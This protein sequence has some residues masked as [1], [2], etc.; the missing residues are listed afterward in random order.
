MANSIKTYVVGTFAV[1]LSFAVMFLFYTGTAKDRLKALKSN[2]NIY[3]VVSAGIS[4]PPGVFSST[5]ALTGTFDTTLDDIVAY[6]NSHTSQGESVLA[7]PM[8]T[9]MIPALAGRHSATRYP[10]PILVMGTPEGQRTYVEDIKRER[11][12]YLVFFPDANFGGLEPVEPYFKP[13]YSYLFSH[14]RPVPGFVDDMAQ[15]IWVRVD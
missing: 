8:Y 10:V 2:I 11:P 1:V 12:R 9:E 3:R 4:W 5:P 7:F 6:L 15:Q 13:V 14:Y